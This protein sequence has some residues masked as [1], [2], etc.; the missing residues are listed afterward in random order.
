MTV[1]LYEQGVIRS[2]VVFARATFVR[3]SCE[4]SY[5]GDTLVDPMRC[6]KSSVMRRRD[7][8]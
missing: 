5:G 4:A 6:S 7:F 1:S 2:N 8:R 3:A